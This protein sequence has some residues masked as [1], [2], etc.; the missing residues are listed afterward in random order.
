MVLSQA[1]ICL[2]TSREKLC[3]LHMQA[4]CFLIQILMNKDAM[5]CTYLY[6]YLLLCMLDLALQAAAST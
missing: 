2:H 5:H 6:A 3:M 1:K 4:D